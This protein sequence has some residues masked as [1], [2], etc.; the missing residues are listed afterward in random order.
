MNPY[1]I[2]Y[3][4]GIIFSAWLLSQYLKDP[5]GKQV[6]EEDNKKNK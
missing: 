4:I 1:I 2:P 6:L 3:I 5:T